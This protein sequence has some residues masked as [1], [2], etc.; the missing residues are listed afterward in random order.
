[1]CSYVKYCKFV[2]GQV[3][4]ENYKRLLFLSINVHVI[5]LVFTS[6]TK[7]GLRAK[8]AAIEVHLGFHTRWAIGQPPLVLPARLQSKTLDSALSAESKTGDPALSVDH[9]FEAEQLCPVCGIADP[10][11]C[12]LLLQLV[13][14]HVCPS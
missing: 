9:Q 10:D 13:D 3:I 5:Y 4:D 1:M 12:Q 14:E 11:L 8:A 6:N 7:R 2:D